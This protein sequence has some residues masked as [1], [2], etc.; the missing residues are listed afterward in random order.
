[1]A[2]AIH[3]RMAPHGY[4]L[5][6][7]N[8]HRFANDLA[9]RIATRS[10]RAHTTLRMRLL[11]IWNSL[12]ASHLF[13]AGEFTKQLVRLP[14]K[15]FLERVLGE[16]TIYGPMDSGFWHALTKEARIGTKAIFFLLTVGAMTVFLQMARGLT[17]WDPEDAMYRAEYLRLFEC[18]PGVS[19]DMASTYL[20]CAF[21][22]PKV[23]GSMVDSLFQA[24]AKGPKGFLKESFELLKGAVP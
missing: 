14:K 24:S 6:F 22:G 19:E 2:K 21:Q 23:L 5:H 10:D 15:V 11:Y 20:M 18:I 17:R 7:N 16:L 1:M 12:P 3:T 8:C 9:E 4:T 13:H